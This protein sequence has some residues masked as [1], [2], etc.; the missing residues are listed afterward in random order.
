MLLP[1]IAVLV[2]STALV[3]VSM[4]AP[5]RPVLPLPHTPARALPARSVARVQ[6][7]VQKQRIIQVRVQSGESNDNRSSGEES[8]AQI[9]STVFPF[10]DLPGVPGLYALTS[11]QTGNVYIGE[12]SDILQRLRTHRSKLHRGEHF[13]TSLQ[14]DFNNHGIADFEVTI[15]AQGPEYLDKATRR[16]REKEYVSR[17]PSEKRY[18]LIDR[19]GE[20]NS[21]AGKTHTL[22]MREHLS[23]ARKGIPNMDLGRPI[24]IPPFRTRK[25]NAHPGGTFASIAEASRVT[26][27]ARRDIRSRINDP[28]FPNWREINPGFDGFEHDNSK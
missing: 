16:A 19:R 26:G 13:C 1:L 3:T 22:D 24:C 10:T 12:S 25:G 2:H 21:F 9:L 27:M 15:L 7:T 6:P 11:R 4:F 14:N 20:R 23:A 17:I 8:L 28:L 18:N 5:R